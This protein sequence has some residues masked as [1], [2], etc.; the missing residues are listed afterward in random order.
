MKRDPKPHAFSSR[1]NTKH[2]SWLRPD[3]TDP[4]LCTTEGRPSRFCRGRVAGGRPSSHCIHPGEG[5][6]ELSGV[7]IIRKGS[8]PLPEDPSSPK[9]LPSSRLLVSHRRVI[10]ISRFELGGH[11]N[12]QTVALTSR[13]T[14]ERQHVTD[15]FFFLWVVRSQMVLSFCFFLGIKKK[16]GVS[17]YSFVLRTDHK[18]TS[19]HRVARTVAEGRAG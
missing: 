4:S 5:T 2:A 14:L 13:K 16:S 8:H 15:D 1:A 12:I 17:I 18:S 10:G 7:S 19:S 3:T 11:T 9:P 6:R